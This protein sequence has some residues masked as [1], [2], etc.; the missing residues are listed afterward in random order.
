MNNY[1]YEIPEPARSGPFKAEN[2]EKT[3][4]IHP[5]VQI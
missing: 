4:Q 1:A 2:V 5:V 3:E